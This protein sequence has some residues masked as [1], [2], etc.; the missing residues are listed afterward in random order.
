MYS[1]MSESE[2]V[3]AHLSVDMGGAALA[4]VEDD[5]CLCSV[6]C[7]SVLEH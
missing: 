4:P 2:G 3:C 7:T 1:E 6:L 5:T